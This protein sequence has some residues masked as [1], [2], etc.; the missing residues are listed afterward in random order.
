MEILLQVGI[1]ISLLQSCVF[2]R[3]GPASVCI[4]GPKFQDHCLVSERRT[5]FTQWGRETFRNNREIDVTA[6]RAC[7]CALLLCLHIFTVYLTLSVAQTTWR[8]MNNKWERMWKDAV[9]L[10]S[11]IFPTYSLEFCGRSWKISHRIR[12]LP[13]WNFN[14]NIQG[15]Q[16]LWFTPST[17]FHQNSS[18]CYKAA[19]CGLAC[20]L[21]NQARPSLYSLNL[22]SSC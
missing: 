18:S 16:R 20:R 21:T 11:G 10:I 5:P 2:L 17:K 22:L 3:N 19:M 14:R 8:R 1:L 7:K 12:D 13:S 4:G 9:R 15:K 6:A